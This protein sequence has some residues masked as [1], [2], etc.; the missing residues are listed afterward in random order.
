M[1]YNLREKTVSMWTYINHYKEQFENPFYEADL[2]QQITQ[3]PLTNYFEL[4]VWQEL[5]FKYTTM[6]SSC[7]HSEF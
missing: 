3:I 7:K 2:Q 5:Y 6:P 4:K 1:K